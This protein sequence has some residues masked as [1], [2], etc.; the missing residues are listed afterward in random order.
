MPWRLTDAVEEE[1]KLALRLEASLP[2]FGI[3]LMWM[4]TCLQKKALGVHLYLLYLHL[5][6]SCFFCFAMSAVIFFSCL[7]FLCVARYKSITLVF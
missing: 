6:F 1:L 3:V 7:A 5:C 4:Q 2:T